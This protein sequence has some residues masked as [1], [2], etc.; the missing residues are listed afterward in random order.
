MADAFE[1]M[2]TGKTSPLNGPV[3][4]AQS[5]TVDLTQ[6][7]R[8]IRLPD[9]GTAGNIKVTWENGTESTERIAAGEKHAWRIKRVW[10]AGTTAVG[11]RGYY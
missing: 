7:T 3:T 9:D 8:E 6:V 4:I 10:V 5:D 1:N 11:L 2:A